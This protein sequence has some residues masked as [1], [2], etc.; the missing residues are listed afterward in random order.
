MTRTFRDRYDHADG[1]SMVRVPV[2]VATD[3]ARY[4]VLQRTEGET[5][6]QLGYVRVNRHDNWLIEGDTAAGCFVSVGE[7]ARAL[8]YDLRARMA[9]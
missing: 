9:L 1:L 4:Q 5:P 2:K 6:A 7:A 3:A 8:R